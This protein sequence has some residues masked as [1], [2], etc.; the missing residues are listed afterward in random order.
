[1]T[2]TTLSL[3]S[4]PKTGWTLSV[5]GARRAAERAMRAATVAFEWANREGVGMELGM[6]ALTAAEEAMHAA[7]RASLATTLEAIREEAALAWA[8]AERT[9]AIDR[10]LT[11]TI[12][13]VMWVTEIDRTDEDPTVLA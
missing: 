7:E 13:K 2:P 9:I 12:A 4:D 3:M 6:E 10:R 11:N 1:M 5:S 8:A